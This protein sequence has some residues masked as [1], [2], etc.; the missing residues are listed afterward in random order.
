MKPVAQV[1]V[2]DDDA[3]IRDFVR[4]TLEG[5]GYAVVTA[6]NGSVA[7]QLLSGDS[8]YQPDIILLDMR[9]PIVDGWQF[10]KVY[11]E[12]PGKKVP[13]I[14]LTAA[15]DPAKFAAQIKADNFLP[16]PF[17]LLDL[18]DMVEQFTH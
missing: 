3:P 7:L 12:M 2:I 6:E 1:L 8:P 14:V 18:L 10:A 16:K 13:I 11:R 17:D 9:M 15:T 4:A 5:E